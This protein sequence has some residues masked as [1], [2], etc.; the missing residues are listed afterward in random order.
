MQWLCSWSFGSG[1][2]P[3]WSMSGTWWTLRRNS[4]GS[5]LGL[6]MRPNALVGVL[7]VSH[8][9]YYSRLK[10]TPKSSR[11]FGSVLGFNQKIFSLFCFL[12]PTVQKSHVSRW[13]GL[14]KL[15]LVVNEYTHGVVQP[16]AQCSWNRLQ[17]HCHSD[18]GQAVSDLT[19]LIWFVI[20]GIPLCSRC[21]LISLCGQTVVASISCARV[22]FRSWSGF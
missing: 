13:I 2:K 7:T 20:S 6:S 15:A 3:G 12:P 22:L 11:I 17:V 21:L 10:F 19:W 4:S 9:Y 8:R 5:S 1:D 18:Q 16:H 14:E